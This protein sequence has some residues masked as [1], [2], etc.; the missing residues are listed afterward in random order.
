MAGIWSSGSYFQL[1]LTLLGA[2]S[3]PFRIVLANPEVTFDLRSM[4]ADDFL[5]FPL[6][7]FLQNF[8]LNALLWHLSW[9]LH[10]L[11][12]MISVVSRAFFEKIIPF[13]EPYPDVI[14]FLLNPLGIHSVCSH[15]HLRVSM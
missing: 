4:P 3:V 15:F 11:F 12:N 13:V 2:R 10:H 8:K 7:S 5:F 14:A 6:F 1:I 9:T